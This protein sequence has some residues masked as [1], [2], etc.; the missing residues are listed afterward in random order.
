[1]SSSGRTAGETTAAWLRA[2][3]FEGL[4]DAARQTA[5]DRLG[6]IR[7]RVLAGARITAGA[8][9]VDLGA[10]TGLLTSA[11]LSLVGPAGMVTAVD[12]S[13]EALSQIDL[14]ADGGT[15]RRLVADATRMSLADRCVDAVVARSVLI[16]I[17]DLPAAL[18]EVA[19]VLRPAGRF[20]AF[21]P[22]NARRRHDA[23][24]DGL[25][26]TELIAIDQ[27]TAGATRGAR[28]M[29]A[30][31]ERRTAALARHVGLTIEAVVMDTVRD[32]FTDAAAVEAHLHRR[33]HPGGPTAIETITK[34]LGGDVARRYREAWRR[35]VGRQ[36]T[37]TYTTPVM[38]VTASNAAQ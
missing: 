20:S 7:D 5:E 16:Y 32:T 33:G 11:A 36:G 12:L 35:A 18:A 9:V 23:E 1:M 26:A 4:S 27:A 10:G 14:P 17:D 8:H 15:V 21:E 2:G 13:A 37:I 25:S 19:R 28:T 34:N 24:L 38:Y 31:D 29:T 22:V 6:G 3:R 30:F